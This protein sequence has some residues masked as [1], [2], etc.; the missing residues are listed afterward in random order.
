[1]VS[2]AGPLRYLMFPALLGSNRQNNPE[3]RSPAYAGGS[4]GKWMTIPRIDAVYRWWS[5]TRTLFAAKYCH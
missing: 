4:L 3:L 5:A 1:M 2:V